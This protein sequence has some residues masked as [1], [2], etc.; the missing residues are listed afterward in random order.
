LTGSI[1]GTPAGTKGAAGR[2][3][4]TATEMTAMPTTP[5]AIQIARLIFF[6]RKIAGSRFTSIAISGAFLPDP[7]RNRNDSP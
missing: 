5:R 4:D 3:R 7:R 2:K 1:Q 6:C